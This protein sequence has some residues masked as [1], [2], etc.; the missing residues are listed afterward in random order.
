[1]SVNFTAVYR[2]ARRSDCDERALV[3]TAVDIASAISFDGVQ[4]FL[5]VDVAHAERAFIELGQ[6]ETESRPP[7]PPPPPPRLHGNAWVGCAV[8]VIVLLGIAY[9]IAHGLWRLD[10]FD[11]GELDAGRVQ[12]GQWWRA[13]TALTLHLDA[14]H[15]AANLGAGIWFGYLAG[16]QLGSGNAWFLI[17]NGAALANWLAGEFGPSTHRAVGASTAVFT[18]LGLLAA[19][20]WRTRYHLPQRWALRW[21]PL[22][23]GVILLGWLGSTGEGTDLVGHATGFAVGTLLGAT[24]ALPAVERVLERVPQ[25]LAGLAAFGCM[26]IAWARAMTS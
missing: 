25:W 26:A 22:V 10:A 14:A 11:A 2:S 20:S 12:S 1:M 24:A 5:E 8:Y 19:H 16:R 17:V 21:A 7:P 23:A 6:Y 18:A 3:L 13:W 4:Y 9:A 15:L